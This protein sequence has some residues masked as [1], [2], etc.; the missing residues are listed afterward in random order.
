MQDYATTSFWLATS[1]PYTPSPALCGDV[2]VDVAIIGGGFTGLSTAY[3]LCKDAPELRVAVLEA[4]VVG[5]GASGRNAGFSRIVFGLEPAVTRARFGQQRTIDAYHYLERAV[6]SMRDLVRQH[7]LQSDYEQ[8]GF[9]RVATTPAF[10]RRIQHDLEILTSLGVRGVEWVD[11]TAI[12]SEVDSPHFLGGWWE[13]RCS[14]FNPAKHARELKRIAQA[15]GAQVY[16]Q[17]TVQEIQ[18]GGHFLIRTDG[19]TIMAEKLVFAT[20]AYSH[21]FPQLRALQVPIFTHMVVTEPLTP[22]QLASIGWQNRQGIMDARNFSHYCRLTADN[23][24]AIGGSDISLAYGTD[25]YRDH[26]SQTFAALERKLVWLFPALRG[27]RVTHRWGGPIS[28]TV[29][30]APAIGQIGDRRALYSLGCVGHGVPL[31]HL[32]GRTLAD[33]VLERRSD[34]TDIWF[35]NRHMLRWPPEPLRMVAGQVI[36]SALRLQD[37]FNE[38]VLS[39]PLS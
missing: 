23:R 18:P 17:T 9:L 13:P 38:R 24:L 21:L 29:D 5:F 6:D 7:D 39:R 4:E 30:L 35:V 16:E 37:A 8:S 36:R 31:A 33:L 10:V 26:N 12:R 3:H 34:L 2:R 22:V 1:G 11:A 28:I 25:M 32:N 15:Q 20:N 27:I 19:G 14:L